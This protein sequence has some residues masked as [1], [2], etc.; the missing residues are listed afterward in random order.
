MTPYTDVGF[1]STLLIKTPGRQIA[2]RNLQV[3]E[4]PHMLN[5]LQHLQIENLLVRSRLDPSDRVKA[6]ASEGA[7]LWRFYLREGVFQ[8]G[9]AGWDAALRV[10][11]GWTQS[12]SQNIPFLLILHAALAAES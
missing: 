11:I 10:A 3:F 8:V 12:L 9:S 2:W 5:L 1:L 6:I 7:R 4:P